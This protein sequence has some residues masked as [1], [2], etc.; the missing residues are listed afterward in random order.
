VRQK[1]GPLNFFWPFSQQPFGILIQNFT[2]LFKETFYI[3]LPSTVWF[4]WKTT[5]L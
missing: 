4:C 3:Q 5:K 1:S 2:A